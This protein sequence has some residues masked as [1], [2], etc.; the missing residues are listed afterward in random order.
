MYVIHMFLRQLLIKNKR[1]RKMI[2]NEITTS[3]IYIFKIV[4]L[5]SKFKII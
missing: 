2:Q 4:K 1:I 3:Y 5:R